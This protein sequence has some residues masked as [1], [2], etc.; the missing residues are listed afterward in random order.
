MGNSKPYETASHTRPWKGSEAEH[1]GSLNGLCREL[2]PEGWFAGE[3]SFREHSFDVV[4][5]T[6]TPCQSMR[7]R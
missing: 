5:G 2:D 3:G 1:T 6:V 7:H 4:A